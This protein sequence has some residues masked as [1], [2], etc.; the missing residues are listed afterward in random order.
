MG[1]DTCATDGCELPIHARNRCDTHYRRVLAHG[2]DAERLRSTAPE[3]DRFWTKVDATGD[4]WEW[5]ASTSGGGYGWF[6]CEHGS[7]PAHRWSWE[8]LVGPIPDSLQLDH[9]CRNRGCV[10]PDHLEPVSQAEN[11]ARGVAGAHQLAKTH[12]PQRHPYSGDNLILTGGRRRCRVCT[13]A[14]KQRHKRKLSVK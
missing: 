4:C 7:V 1:D 11:I 9:L 2:T 14:A 5:T 10:N 6:M 13:R 3:A 12:C 8:H